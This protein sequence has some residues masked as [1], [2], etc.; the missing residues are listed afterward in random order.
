VGAERIGLVVVA[1][2]LVLMFFTY[3]NF[4]QKVLMITF[5]DITP[6]ST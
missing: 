4:F 2:V 6:N 5:D 1:I 3:A